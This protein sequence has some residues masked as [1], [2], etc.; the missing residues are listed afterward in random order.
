[1]TT[2]TFAIVDDAQGFKAERRYV[3]DDKEGERIMQCYCWGE[4]EHDKAFT[5]IAAQLMQTITDHVCA[6]ERAHAAEPIV[7][8]PE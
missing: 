1:M 2:F 4:K 8:K 7:P 6:Y 3:V 5:A